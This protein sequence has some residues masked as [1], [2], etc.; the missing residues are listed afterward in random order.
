MLQRMHAQLVLYRQQV[1]VKLYELYDIQRNFIF[2]NMINIILMRKRMDNFSFLV[3]ILSNK[4]L[5]AII[6]DYQVRIL[7]L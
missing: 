6:V 1:I 2:S 5:Y 3:E 7:R 4:K